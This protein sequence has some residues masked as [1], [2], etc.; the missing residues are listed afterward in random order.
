MDERAQLSGDRRASKL[1]ELSVGSNLTHGYRLICPRNALP[2]VDT[3]KEEC[4]PGLNILGGTDAVARS[5]PK[6]GGDMQV[7][8]VLLFA[9]AGQSHCRTQRSSGFGPKAA[10]QV[11]VEVQKLGEDLLHE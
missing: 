8:L 6:A 10:M 4:E 7:R 11:A 1:A 9:A 3:S 5:C 2:R